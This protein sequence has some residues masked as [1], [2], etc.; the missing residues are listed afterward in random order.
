[1]APE[2]NFFEIALC[3]PGRT[4][5]T[6]PCNAFASPPKQRMTESGRFFFEMADV[7]A[8]VAFEDPLVIEHVLPLASATSAP[9]GLR[10]L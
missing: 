9:N 5:G 7:W 4:T 8:V 3:L 10:E 2:L 1:M 6:L